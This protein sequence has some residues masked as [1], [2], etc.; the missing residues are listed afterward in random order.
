MKRSIVCFAVL[1]VTLGGCA[2]RQTCECLSGGGLPPSTPEE[3]RARSERTYECL[4]RTGGTIS[5]CPQPPSSP[6]RTSPYASPS[7]AVPE[8]PR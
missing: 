2:K 6:P 5:G 8:S 7:A 1:V 4:N 3:Q